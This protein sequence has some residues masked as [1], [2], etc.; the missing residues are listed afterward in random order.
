MDKIKLNEFLR[1]ISFNTEYSFLE[2][3]KDDKELEKIAK[4]RGIKLPAKDLAIFKG[5]YA[6]TDRTNLNG[7]SLPKAEVAKSLDTLIGKAID[8]D[9]IRERIVGF[10]LDAELI[11][12]TI[13]AYGAFFKENLAEDYEMIKDLMAN[14]NLGIS[15]EAYGVREFK[16]DNTY[17]LTDIEWAGGALL[18]NTKPAFPGA[19]VLEMANKRVLEYASIMTEPK[20]Y[21]KSPEEKRHEKARMYTNDMQIMM[22]LADETVCPQCGKQGCPTINSIDFEGLSIDAICPQCNCTMCVNMKPES[23]IEVE[24]PNTDEEI[25]TPSE[26]DNEVEGKDRV[27]YL[28]VPNDKTTERKD[29]TPFTF[30]PPGVKFS[31][32][33]YKVE[34][35]DFDIDETIYDHAKVL[36]TKVR[37]ALPDS[38]FALVKVVKNKVTGKPRKIRMF[39]IHDATHVRSALSYLGHPKV[40]ENLR[41]MG[42]SVEEVRNKV[43]KKAKKFNIKVNESA[44]AGKKEEQTMSEVKTGTPS[45]E[46][47]E[48]L[49]KNEEEVIV[50]KAAEVE[51]VEET[52]LETEIAEAEKEVKAEEANNLPGT[53]QPSGKCPPKGQNLPGC[54][55]PGPKDIP[56]MNT[57]D[58]ED[59]KKCGENS[60]VKCPTCGSMVD[61]KCMKKGSE[62][63]QVTK[64]QLAKARDEG[65]IIGERRSLLKDYAKDMSDD[66]ILDEVKYENASLK[67]RVAELEAL[68]TVEKSSVVKE[69]KKEETLEIGSKDKNKLS[70]VDDLAKNVRKRAF[71]L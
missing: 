1:D 47:A 43:I 9:H 31:N 42:V 3:G 40:Q 12:D 17:D 27:D 33:A 68:K 56:S 44:N 58:A 54:A 30:F 21:I 45:I 4:K 63:I 32:I 23:E 59:A 66:D 35:I 48:S 50:E 36:T 18:I 49:I 55:E 5:K 67:K 39:P 46:K 65:K 61:A 64:E 53:P 11:K 20:D 13:F 29:M 71:N 57:S 15:F 26:D 8:F 22:R 38:Q 62:E 28:V 41:K 6:F 16:K 52:K 60:K 51:E 70:E 37:N 14:K 24:L 25:E 2:E 19:G 34:E 10:W 7:C 69:V